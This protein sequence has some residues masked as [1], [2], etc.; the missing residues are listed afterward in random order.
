MRVDEVITI[1]F[2]PP[3][4]P[5]GFDLLEMRLRNSGAAADCRTKVWLLL[6]LLRMLLQARRGDARPTCSRWRPR[7]TSPILSCTRQL[8]PWHCKS[9][10]TRDRITLARAGFSFR[11]ATLSNIQRYRSTTHTCTDGRRA[12]PSVSASCRRSNWTAG[13]PDGRCSA[14]AG[15]ADWASVRDWWALIR[16][17][18]WSCSR[19]PPCRQRR[20][21][22]GSRT[23]ERTS[24]TA[25]RAP[26]KHPGRWD[27]GNWL[28]ALPLRRWRPPSAAMAELDGRPPCRKKE[29]RASCTCWAA[30]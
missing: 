15:T 8:I 19:C 2:Q 17:W 18:I 13:R 10:R 21:R 20:W 12:I 3:V 1:A 4:F 7:D 11:L 24:W 5:W 16:C 9:N 25:G 30:W 29:A 26:D 23:N 28:P 22:V 27:D 14:A 6:L